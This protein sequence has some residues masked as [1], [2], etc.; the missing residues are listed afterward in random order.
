MQHPLR[1][2]WQVGIF[3]IDIL[4]DNK[5]PGGF[6]HLPLRKLENWILV[7]QSLWINAHVVYLLFANSDLIGIVNLS[8]LPSLVTEA[9]SKS[10]INHAR[11]IVLLKLVA[12]QNVETLLLGVAEKDK[13][14]FRTMC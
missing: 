8:A 13:K 10:S 3:V 14:R 12:G 7:K 9:F 11:D 4:W 1:K 6:V 2:K 5:H